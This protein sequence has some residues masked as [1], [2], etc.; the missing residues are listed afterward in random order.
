MKCSCVHP[1]CAAGPRAVEQLAVVNVSST[2]VWLSWLV[3][4]AR[5]AAATQLRLSLLP[6]NASGARTAL[7]NGSVSEFSFR[8]VSGCRLWECCQ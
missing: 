5:H 8:S 2:A 7:L 1:V 4:A 6:A 3:Q